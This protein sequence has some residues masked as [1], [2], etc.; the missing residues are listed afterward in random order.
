MRICIVTYDEYA[1]IPYICKYE[2]LLKKYNINYDIV[3]W[4]RTNQGNKKA[5]HVN[6]IYEFSSETR[7]SK[8]SKVVPFIKWRRFLLKI[9]RKNRYD[10]LI[11]VTTI[12]GVLISKYL[13][14]NYRDKYLF[15]I[16]DYTYE[17]F[18]LYKN[19]VDKLVEYSSITSISSEGFM[20]WLKP[21]SK[22]VLN[23]NISNESTETS[24]IC[25]L[26][27]IKKLT[28]GFVGGI[29]YFN[30]NIAIINSLKNNDK[31]VVSYIGK[32]HPGN[33]LQEYCSENNINNVLFGQRFKNE[34]K[35]IIYKNIDII[36]AVYGSNSLE[37][38]TAL[39]NKLYDCI[40]FKKPI[41]V[42]KGTYLEKIVKKY[43]LGFSVD[44]KKDNILDEINTYI[45]NF[46]ENVFLEGC[47]K[48][49]NK[50]MQEENN[51]INRVEEFFC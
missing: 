5:K 24:K 15:D 2:T 25:S 18:N 17:G 3:L 1:N 37:V 38:K 44:I 12:P 11:I 21:N 31:F 4:N 45:D 6:N 39:P 35:P 50:V 47:N 19:V 36:N 27:N 9:L 33:D 49:L 26:K 28:I 8:L 16:R 41:I 43:K 10:K 30:E 20:Q 14:K 42:S 29:R 32:V 34:E 7:K 48:Y 13:F 51:F 23:H 40:I 22:V 46:N